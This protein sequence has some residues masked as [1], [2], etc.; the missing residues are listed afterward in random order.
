MT[1][2]PWKFYGRH[3]EAAR[4]EAFLDLDASFSAL[5][6]RGRRQVGKSDF[7]RHFFGSRND[8]TPVVIQHLKN[9]SGP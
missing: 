4:I 7:I 2:E 1:M 8:A 3:R 9:I 6:V 5:V